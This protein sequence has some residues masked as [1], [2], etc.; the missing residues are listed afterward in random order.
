MSLDGC[1]EW[2][3]E[4]VESI[5]ELKK[6]VEIGETGVDFPLALVIANNGEFSP[7]SLNAT[8]GKGDHV[9][10]VEVH[11]PRQNI[12]KNMPD[13]NCMIGLM[14][15]AYSDKLANI[16]TDTRVGAIGKL[17]YTRFLADI[18]SIP[19]HGLTFTIPMQSEDEA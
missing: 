19:T 4:M 17:A 15:K 14:R 1:I 6:V 12:A 5:P 7:A 13:S 18:G 16:A 10:F 11:Y 9:L 3:Q 2:V 8:I